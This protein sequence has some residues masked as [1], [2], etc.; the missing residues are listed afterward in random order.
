MAKKYND[1]KFELKE[2]FAEEL[3]I[4]V[5]HH[6]HCINQFV[7]GCDSPFNYWQ[8]Q[9]VQDHLRAIAEILCI[10]DEE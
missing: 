7:A 2:K 8:I 4:S 6:C 5:N 1:I 3:K 10:K 9:D